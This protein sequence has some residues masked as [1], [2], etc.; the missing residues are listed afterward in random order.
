MDLAKVEALA[1]AEAKWFRDGRPRSMEATSRA[2]GTMPRGV[3]VSWMDE[4]PSQDALIVAEALAQRYGMAKWQFTLSATQANT[5]VVR[6]ARARTG[7]Q[8]V[9]VFDGKYH[10]HLEPTLGIV[11]DGRVLPEYTGLRAMPVAPG[12]PTTPACVR[13][14]GC[15]SPTAAYGSRAGG[16]GR[17]FRSPTRHRT[18]RPTSTR[19]GSSP[20]PSRECPERRTMLAGSASGGP[21]WRQAG[22][23]LAELPQ[24][25]RG[26]VVARGGRRLTPLALDVVPPGLARYLR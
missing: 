17:Q 8:K 3:P 9:V 26:R 15:S 1:A 23:P 7:R 6:I 21:S 14:S 25:P 12:T 19:S 22:H 10:G 13:S 2:A 5:E 11:E 24:F 16:S 4:Q 18:W 20:K